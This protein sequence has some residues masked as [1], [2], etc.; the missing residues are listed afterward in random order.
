MTAAGANETAAGKAVI[1]ENVLVY[2]KYKLG[3]LVGDET[4]FIL[5]FNKDGVDADIGDKITVKGI[6]GEYGGL[7][8]ITDP[9]LT[10]GT[11]GNAITH[12]TAKDI[13]SELD[14]YAAATPEY[15]S[16]TGT[17][18]I[19]GSYYNL[20]REW[21]DQTRQHPVSAGRCRVR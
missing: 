15:V 6:V 17:L 13:T 8:Q 5:V 16:L 3:I 10:P 9:E 20:Y 2:A 7:K 1:L 21:R 18:S 14:S 11:T 19:S 12:P 4:G